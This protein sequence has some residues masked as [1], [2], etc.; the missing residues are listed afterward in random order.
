MDRTVPPGAARLLDFIG[1]I[2][3]P[4]GYDTLYGNAQKRYP[5]R[6]T[7]LTIGEVL[8]RGSTWP[9]AHGSSACGRYQ[10]MA[11]PG[12]TLAGLCKELRLK[13]DQVFDADLQDRLGYHLLRRRGYDQFAAGELS[14]VEFAKRLAQEWASLP[15]LAAT[16]GAKRFVLRGQSYYVGDGLNKALVTPERVEAVLA[17]TTALIRGQPVAPTLQAEAKKVEEK[18]TTEAAGAATTG[19]GTAGAAAVIDP[20]TFDWTAW[21][22]AVFLAVGAVTLVVFLIHRALLNYQ[23]AKAYRAVA[24]GDLA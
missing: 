24:S 3:A 12:H 17:A 18:A 22:F 23:R 8:A 9:K 7:D 2:E 6:L 13:S 15:V 11:G 14:A 5:W 20:G 1:S 21:L 16:K 4:Q 19:V 10:F